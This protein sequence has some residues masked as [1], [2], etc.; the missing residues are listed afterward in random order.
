VASIVSEDSSVI[1]KEY[2]VRL[3]M[4]SKYKATGTSRQQTWLLKT[5]RS[6]ADV[7]PSRS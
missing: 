1:A 5:G 2:I 6:P 3:W 4:R 7:Y